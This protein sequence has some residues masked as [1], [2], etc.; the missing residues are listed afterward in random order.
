L[1]NKFI[2]GLTLIIISLLIIAIFQRQYRDTARLEEQTVSVWKEY[3]SLQ[4]MA[5]MENN[6]ARENDHDSS[7]TSTEDLPDY[8]QLF[9]NLYTEKNLTYTTDENKKIAY[10]SFDDGPSKNTAKV[11]EVLKDKDVKAT[12]FIVGSAITEEGEGYLKQMVEEGHT[13]GIHTYSHLCNEIYCSIE[14][15]LDDF[16]M[17][18][19]QIY[20]IT[21]MKV[22]IYRFPWGS[23]NGYSKGIKDSLT[24]EMDRRGFSY[25]DWTASADDSIGKPSAYSIRHNIEKD[26]DRDDH[27]IILMHDSV[28]N[29]L[30]AKTL[31]DIIDMIREKGYSFDTLDHR[32]PYHFPW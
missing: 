31:P 19:Q 2:F 4:L 32:E 30:T 29:G 26:L 5:E 13:I 25:Y 12:F 11:L 6:I 17:V 20:D 27:P 22:N 10:L 28:I 14:R 8:T 23:S 15:Y 3:E 21:G 16:N 7:L 1:K 18:Y 9:P 24:E